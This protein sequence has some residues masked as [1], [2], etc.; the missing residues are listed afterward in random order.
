MR[1]QTAL[2]SV[3]LPAPFGPSRPKNAPSGTSRSKRVER[4]RAVVVALGEPAELEGGRGWHRRIEGTPSRDATTRARPGRPAGLG[5]RPRLHGHERVLRRRPT[6]TSRSRRSTARSTSAS[7]SS[8]PPTCTAPA[9]TRS[10][11]AGR[12]R[13]RRDEVVLATKFGNVR[14]ARTA[15]F[16]RRRRA[17]P[18]TCARPARRACGGWASTHIDLY[19]QHRVDPNVPIEETVGAMAEL[20]EAGKVRYLGLSEAAPATIRRAHAAH[21]IAALQ[22]EYSLWTPRRGGRGPARRCASSASA[23]SPTGRSAAA[24]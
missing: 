23:S 21:P 13:G 17:I 4:E 24:S 7:P 8:T 6:R 15:S 5:D 20:V 12:S 2:I 14:D 19:Y 18:S 16:L 22:T 10:W 9:R 3:V 1:L 11:S